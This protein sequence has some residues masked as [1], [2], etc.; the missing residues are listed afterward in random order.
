MLVPTNAL[1]MG[2]LALGRIPY[3]RWFRFIVPLLVKIYAV[4][5]VALAALVLWQ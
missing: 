3:Q 4:A 5:L 1:L 2:M